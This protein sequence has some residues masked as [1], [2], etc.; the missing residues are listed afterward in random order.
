[1]SDY[2]APVAVWL[3]PLLAVAGYLFTR[4]LLPRS[5]SVFMFDSA[6]LF[7]VGSLCIVFWWR[8][9]TGHIP[10]D[11]W[12]DERGFMLLLVPMWTSIISVPLL[13]VAA[14]VRGLVFSRTQSDATRAT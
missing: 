2:I 4:R 1:M 5:R 8:E 14:V 13:L 6:A 12:L 7:F 9:I 3:I 11:I 10:Q